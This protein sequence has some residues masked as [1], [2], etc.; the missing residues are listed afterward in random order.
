MD[1]SEALF[2]KPTSR[3]EK[4]IYWEW[5]SAGRGDNWPA[6]GIRWANWKLLVGRNQEPIE[7]FHFPEDR[8]E[9]QNVKD[10][11]PEETKA[12]IA[13]IDTWKQTLPKEADRKL[14]SAER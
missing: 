10:S 4:A 5:R 8:L 7:L 14:W 13:R 1:Q 11:H 9:R 3:R 12:L 6:A 2:G